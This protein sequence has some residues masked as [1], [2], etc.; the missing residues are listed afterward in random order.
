MTEIHPAEEGDPSALQREA[1]LIAS[2]E[3]QLFCSGIVSPQACL[4][5][6]HS[7]QPV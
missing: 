5:S 4:Q 6:L 1:E 2:F 3:I 7:N